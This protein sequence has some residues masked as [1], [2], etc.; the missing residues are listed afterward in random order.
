MELIWLESFASNWLAQLRAGRTPHAV[1]LQGP[2]GVGKRCAAAWMMRHFLRLPDTPELPSYP[3][4]VAEHADLRW[5]SIP[6]DKLSIGIDQIRAL[7]SEFHLT[8]YEG[9]GKAAVI[10]PANAMTVN[11]ANS[12]LKTL[13][14]PPGASLLILVADRTSHIP[15]TIMSR[16]QRISIRVPSN[17][18]GLQ[19]LNSRQPTGNWAAALAIAGGAPLAALEALERLPEVDEMGK[20]FVALGERNATPLEVASRWAAGDIAFILDWLSRAVRDL[21]YRSCGTAARG[22]GPQPGESVLRRIDSRNLFCYL[23]T[24]DRL[25]AQKAGSFNA[26]LALESLLIDWTTGLE[27]YCDD[28]PPTP[29]G[30]R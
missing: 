5:V 24:I 6:E 4:A 25:R 19:W 9:G 15:A 18:A 8:S 12:L 10:E 22:H 3:L 2:A 17:G 1:V 14:E 16:C 26:Q 20:D 23:D 21:I 7:V 30:L 29:L 28:Q 11:A 27:G 13:E